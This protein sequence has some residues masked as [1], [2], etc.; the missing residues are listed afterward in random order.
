MRKKIMPYNQLSTAE[1]FERY[2]VFK[3]KKNN[4]EEWAEIKFWDSI[5]RPMHNKIG[6]RRDYIRLRMPM[7]G[8]TF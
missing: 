6:T 3:I 5:N 7:I 2:G 4:T 1:T 8:L